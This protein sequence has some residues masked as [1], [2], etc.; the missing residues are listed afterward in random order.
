MRG[1]WCVMGENSPLTFLVSGLLALATAGADSDRV[2]TKVELNRDGVAVVE[3]KNENMKAG[4]TQ[5][6]AEMLAAQKFNTLRGRVLPAVYGAVTT[7][8]LWR[9][10]RLQDTTVAVDSTEHAIEQVERIVGILVGMVKA[11]AGWTVD[12]RTE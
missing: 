1:A 11:A 2:G 5:C 4:I 9:F 10:L 8:V 7:G 6:T 3:A 12:T